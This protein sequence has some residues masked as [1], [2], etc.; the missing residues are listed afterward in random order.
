MNDSAGKPS[1]VPELGASLTY[2]GD[3]LAELRRLVRECRT[4]ALG[5]RL[6]GE[7]VL[8]RLPVLEE[9]VA[10]LRE[11]FEAMRPE[12]PEGDAGMV[13]LAHRL[14]DE[15]VATRAEMRMAEHS[16]AVRH[17]LAAGHAA[18]HD[19]SLAEDFDNALAFLQD[20]RQ[21]LQESD[22][23]AA[24]LEAGSKAAM[25]EAQVL[26]ERI[27][28]GERMFGTPGQQVAQARRDL[29]ALSGI[30][31]SIPF[32]L[33]YLLTSLARHPRQ[34][35]R[36]IPRLA[37]IVREALARRRAA[38]AGLARDPMDAAGIALP[39]EWREAIDAARERAA[40][41]DAQLAVAAIAAP[42][43]GG[44]VRHERP[45]SVD[46]LRLAIV[47]DE[48]TLA[49]VRRHCSLLVVGRNDWR[50]S[51]PGFK[52]H[53][54]LVES[55]WNGNDGAWAGEVERAGPDL[56]ALL[57]HCRA[58]G[59]PTVF[60][61]KEDPVHFR[62]FLP[63]AAL[64][65]FV[66]TTDIDRIPDYRAHLRHDRIFL[67]PFAVNPLERNPVE[68]GVR[69]DA[70]SFA[71]S[72]YAKYPARN[73]AF[74]TICEVVR[75]HVPLQIYDRN[76]G[77]N[78]PDLAFP[79]EFQP[80]IVG[81]LPHESIDLAYKGYR[82][83]ITVNSAP[84]S[85]TMAARRVFDLLASN[86][87]AISNYS[88]ALKLMLGDLLISSDDPEELSRRW[89]ELHADPVHAAKVRLA[90]LRKVMAEHTIEHRLAH[91]VEV[92]FGGSCPVWQ[93]E[94][95]VVGLARDQAGHDA[96]VAAYQRQA[97]P[98][99]RLR[100]VLAPGFE[101]AA[102]ISGNDIEVF[103]AEHAAADP[104]VAL[105]PHGYAACFSPHDHYGAT[106]LADLA[107]GVR[108][109][110]EGSV[111]KSAFHRWV[112]GAVQ[113]P[114]AQAPRYRGVDALALRRALVPV[115]ELGF[116]SL[117]ELARGIEEGIHAQGRCTAL[118][119][120]S[121]CHG[122]SGN[123]VHVVEG[124]TSVDPGLP[125]QDFLENA[126]WMA[127]GGRG[128]GGAHAA[129]DP[130]DVRELFP[131]ATH[132][133]GK[134]VVTHDTGVVVSSRQAE[135]EWCYVYAARSLNMH[136]VS[137]RGH[138][139]FSLSASGKLQVRAA[140]IFN[141]GNGDRMGAVQVPVNVSHR[142]SIP[143]GCQT[144]RLAVRVVGPGK[145]AINGLA[146][147]DSRPV[148]P[149]AAL[150]TRSS[151]L[152]LAKGYPSRARLYH[153][154]FVHRRVLAYREAGLRHAVFR[155]DPPDLSFDEFQGID[156]IAG[157][158]EHLAGLLQR[159]RFASIDIHPLY[160]EMWNVLRAHLGRTPMNIWV[161]GAEIQPWY[162]RP[163]NY[164]AG[165]A[166]DRA[167]RATAT[168]L[169]MWRELFR[170]RHPNLHF[171]F[172]SRYLA[173]QAMADV[174]VE[175]APAQYSIIHNYIDAQVF[176]YLP[177]PA[178]QRRRI[179]SIR[180]YNSPVYANDLSVKAVLSLA[181]EPFFQ[182][183]E[184]LFVGDGELFESTLEPLRGLPN[185]EI[186]KGFLTQREIAALHKEFGLF[187]V[188][189]RMDSQ[190]VSRDEAMA[191]G[192]VPLTNAVAAVPEFVDESVGVLAP[193]E[194]W[195]AL[196]DGIREMYLDPSLFLRR[197][198][199]AAARVREQSGYHATIAREI[200]LVR[201]GDAGDPPSAGSGL[202]PRI[203]FALYG[204][205]NLNITD[206]SAIWAISLAQVLAGLPGAEVTVFLKAP[207]TT[208]HIIEPLLSL[209]NVRL[210]EPAS[211]EGPVL[212][213]SAALESIVSQHRIRPFDAVVLRGFDLCT[214][215]TRH[216]EL[217]G[218]LWVYITDLPQR[219]EDLDQAS[220]E[221]IGDIV[222]H[223]RY[224]LCQT[225]QFRDHVHECFPEARS[226][227]AILP[228]MIPA[229][230]DA[231][232]AAAAGRAL[233]MVYA[234][235]FAPLW[236]IREMLDVFQRVRASHPGFELHVFGD[237]IHNVA[238]DPE[239]RPEIAHRLENTPGLVWH[240]QVSRDHLMAELPG[241]DIGWAWRH[242]DLEEGTHEL[243][244]KVLEYAACSL[245]TVVF[246]NEVNLGV[247][248]PAYP[249][250]ARNAEEAERAISA[251]L[252][253]RARLSTARAG[254][255][256]VARRH[257]FEAVRRD[258][259]Q[260][261]CDAVLAEAEAADG[262]ARG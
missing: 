96:I 171:V 206:G 75:D 170:L 89:R 152:L 248:G 12:A 199:A 18:E 70:C 160:P 59:I 74:R 2:L 203:R 113:A 63:A 122:G 126:R 251:I 13:A 150:M 262:D 261:L 195:H 189:T 101:P 20:A 87:F 27:A 49:D 153:Y 230:A 207:I 23:R 130:Y 145:L 86:T 194:D 117:L 107:A 19:R 90:A 193:A 60:W 84:H 224:V 97:Y 72:H 205:L 6:L 83:G 162:R 258:Y 134:V 81:R 175:L 201:H 93:P 221:R 192:L 163:Y 45:E 227:T 58:Q 68:V 42:D 125:L 223:A 132:A 213:V 102:R 169:A 22:A 138:F 253:D 228:P 212:G 155:W 61:N 244:T 149:K 176:D 88:R 245:P 24:E 178:E 148:A 3:A 104:L 235:K 35:P 1:S 100:I 182:D 14:L 17:G 103:S 66:A 237:K 116:G 157:S 51:L 222:R 219:E 28:R 196:A 106:Y 181:G 177:K 118:D 67:M 73:A 259:M 79:D 191:S 48:F 252:D 214:A 185:V 174:G 99:R 208:L 5:G 120:F 85:Q 183:L 139:R 140:V 16:T 44:G 190:G 254:L 202:H 128:K 164:P 131:R 137:N 52:P 71:G 156:V 43:A 187:L 249:L 121:Y 64:F 105:A 255:A 216:P 55:A 114:P 186:R 158:S 151:R 46:A 209:D 173:E 112:D 240:R 247:F 9:E 124:T 10:R 159:N 225:P 82:Y 53:V 243:S 135:G 119:E 62:H 246:P 211:E 260:P 8:A 7:Q 210:I 69:Q 108:Y 39:L 36:A 127:R 154:S 57:S 78:D 98:R 180:P 215:A 197:S 47:A 256:D 31:T 142:L 147:G 146:I 38:R 257:T 95:T 41:D 30:S 32:Q 26:N 233:R 54:L 220:R 231:P 94:I 4:A 91:L 56:R 242:A 40:F 33:G 77:T 166:R 110:G 21:A 11:R 143:D 218:K 200:A 250:Y 141:D 232:P 161:H 234:G 129:S 236:G 204:D 168:R 198:A 179:L 136:A 29:R 165:P 133:H 50:R 15:L 34:L 115:Q 144:I 241:Y 123:D 80:L 111:G 92:V 172:V 188:P 167:V 65:D 25:A 229:A 109:V 226:R 37:R 238:D 217:A 184:F 76:H 239:F